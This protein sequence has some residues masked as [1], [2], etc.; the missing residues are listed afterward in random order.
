MNLIMFSY[1]VSVILAITVLYVLR[2]SFGSYKQHCY[3]NIKI[4][5]LIVKYLG[6]YLSIQI[7]V[8][9]PSTY[10]WKS[11]FLSSSFSEKVLTSFL[12]CPRWMVKLLLSLLPMKNCSSFRGKINCALYILSIIEL[13]AWLEWKHWGFCL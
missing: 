11:W 9:Y 6:K 8:K 2:L 5:F 4:I 3:S 12:A 10:P 13:I 1:S 7:S